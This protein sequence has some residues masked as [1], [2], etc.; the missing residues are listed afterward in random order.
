MTLI[1]TEEVVT[2]RRSIS[3]MQ[4][5]DRV[6]VHWHII[7]SL[8]IFGENVSSC[9]PQ[10]LASAECLKTSLPCFI[11][12]SCLFSCHNEFVDVLSNY[13]TLPR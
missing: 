5:S 12:A 6:K 9:R 1:V 8:F 11:H 3:I 2:F 7:G 4:N 13:L 10:C